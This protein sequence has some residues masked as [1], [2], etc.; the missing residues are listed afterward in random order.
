MPFIPPIPDIVD[1]TFHTKVETLKDIFE[2]AAI[3]VGG[4]WTYFHY[5][6]GRTF[7][8]RLELSLECSVEEGG[9]DRKY[10]IAR[11]TLKCVGLARVPIDQHGSGLIIYAELPRDDADLSQPIEALWAQTFAAVN[12][13]RN[14]R[15]I[16]AEEV[17][18]EQMMIELPKEHA[19][20]YKLKL[21]INSKDVTWTTETTASVEHDLRK[22]KQNGNAR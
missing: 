22:E 19:S 13:F 17:V 4:A 3:V 1:A 21:K 2:I 11:M 12:V 9:G 18:H 20:A 6:K 10:I 8:S 5:I 7:K 16:E 14:H 15:W